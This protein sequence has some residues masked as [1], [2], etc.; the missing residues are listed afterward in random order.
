MQI[1]VLTTSLLNLSDSLASF[2][3]VDL[4]LHLKFLLSGILMDLSQHRE[5]LLH[6]GAFAL[7]H[8]G[9]RSNTRLYRATPQHSTP[10]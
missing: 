1:M 10:S 2:H 4:Y 3:I 7:S 6:S 5:N 9:P 8:E